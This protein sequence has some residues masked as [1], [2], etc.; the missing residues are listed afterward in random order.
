MIK[1]LTFAPA[2]GDGT[3]FYRLAGVMS[4]LEQEYSDIEVTDIS[5]NKFIDWYNLIGADILLFQRPFSEQHFAAIK[6][7]RNMNIK[8]IVDY[9]DDLFNIPQDNPVH[10]GF[11]PHKETMKSICQ[12]VDEVWVS[13][14][15]IRRTISFW[16][17]NITIIPNAHN[18]YLLPVNKKKEFNIETKK[19]AYRGGTTHEVDVYS[20]VDEWADIINNNKD[21]EF[22]FLGARFLFL[23]S[24]CGD[25]YNAMVGMHIID[26]FKFFSELNPNIFIYTL[27][28]TPFNRAKSNISWIE[29]TYAGASVIAPEFLPEFA[30]MPGIITYNESMSEIFNNI[31]QPLN[32]LAIT[33]D[34]SWKYIKENL[35]LSQV[36]NKRYQSLLALKNNK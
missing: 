16:N 7:A 27:K 2:P 15:A 8:I 14:D 9:D 1:I 12:I 28:D 25:N 24:L 36:N 31:K 26:Y 13:T 30:N 10:L 34:L 22:Y 18:D 23:E 21:F 6:M 3:S 33:N 5:N 35:L 4:Y 29:A 17:K 11:E 32:R 19:V 20:K